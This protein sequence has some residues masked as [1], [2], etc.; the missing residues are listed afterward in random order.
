MKKIKL[1]PL[2]ITIFLVSWLGVLPSLLIAHGVK[3]PTFLK[4][5]HILMTLGTLL[6]SAIFV[7]AVQGRAGLKA[8]F[9]RLLR[10]KTSPWVFFIA[11]G[12][13]IIIWLSGTWLGLMLSNTVWP[14]RFTF[15]YVLMQGVINFVMYLV[16]NTE[17]IAWRGV[18]FDQ[19][20]QNN[21][22]IGACLI[23]APIWW[24]FHI[25]LF[26][27]PGGHPAGYGLIEF[28][29]VVVA[30][31]FILGWLYIKTKRSVLYVHLNHQLNNGF[32]EAL[33]VFPVFIGGNL[34]PFRITIGLSVLL[35]V[36]LVISARHWNKTPM[37]GSV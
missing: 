4:H 3:L 29:L 19:L 32:A 27:Y 18:V 8:L 30:Q 16:V 9:S 28:T 25:P 20:L 22:Y 15:D 31:T 35:A 33:P 34:L 6:V 10:I 2:I 23:L 13:P 12:L 21:T 26:M 1:L 37:N 7:W 11:I 5:F 36:V 14:A 17:E 24:L